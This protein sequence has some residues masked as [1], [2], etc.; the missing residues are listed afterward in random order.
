MLAEQEAMQ[1]SADQRLKNVENY[2]KEYKA[3]TLNL[4]D[5]LEGL[6][7]HSIKEGKGPTIKEGD[8]VYLYYQV[9]LEEN[10]KV[11]DNQF[12][13]GERLILEIGKKDQYIA[14]FQLAVQSMKEGESAC[15]FVPVELAYGEEGVDPLIPPMAKMVLDIEI[16]AVKADSSKAID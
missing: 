3:G 9:L 2:L 1:A 10:G 11:L 7:Y 15:F 16:V 14:A 5:G 6:K 13:R 12:K 8:K 4:E